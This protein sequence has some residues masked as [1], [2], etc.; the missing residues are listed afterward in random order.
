[1]KVLI[2]P[3]LVDVEN[4]PQFTHIVNMF[5]HLD[6]CSVLTQ[7]DW[8]KIHASLHSLAQEAFELGK[9]ST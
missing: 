8:E 9:E 7:D 1:M 6:N 5:K 2:T 4:S 3:T